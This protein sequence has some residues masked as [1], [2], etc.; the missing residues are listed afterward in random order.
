LLNDDFDVRGKGV[1][2]RGISYS[3]V[4]TIVLLFVFQMT[5]LVDFG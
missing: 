4:V 1:C 3:M 5:V 2:M